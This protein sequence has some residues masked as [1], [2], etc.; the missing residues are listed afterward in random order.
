MSD[1]QSR[2]KSPMEQHTRERKRGE[3]Q[4][5]PATSSECR[6]GE[7]KGAPARVR[8]KETD[9]GND[10][11]NEGKGNLI[12]PFKAW[13]GAAAKLAEEEA[14]QERWLA[15]LQAGRAAL[16]ARYLGHDRP[17]GL[18]GL[19]EEATHC[20]ISELSQL[21]EDVSLED[22]GLLES[23]STDELDEGKKKDEDWV[24]VKEDFD[25]LVFL[26]DG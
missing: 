9:L 7:D 11:G 10:N 3:P 16:Q 5:A 21:M 19:D 26:D 12:A 8:A 24:V 2:Y 18:T 1:R 25:V 14:S 22:D 15:R 13:I 6:R 17:H 20:S 4:A 23:E